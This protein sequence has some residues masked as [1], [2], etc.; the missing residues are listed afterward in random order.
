MQAN[1]RTYNDGLLDVAPIDSPLTAFGRGKRALDRLVDF[2][3]CH[4]AE[5]EANGTLHEERYFAIREFMAMTDERGQPHPRCAPPRGPLMCPPPSRCPNAVA[6]LFTFIPRVKHLWMYKPNARRRGSLSI[7]R[8]PVLH[9]PRR[10]VC[11]GRCH[12]LPRGSSHT[13]AL[14]PTPNDHHLQLASDA[15]YHG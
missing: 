8:R 2:I 11:S 3:D 15:T 6:R 10:A 13:Y 4:I 14:Q 12:Q 9:V 5:L 1:F 7:F